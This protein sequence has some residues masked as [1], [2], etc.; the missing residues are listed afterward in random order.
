MSFEY[1]DAEASQHNMMTA[2]LPPWNSNNDSSAGM[3]CY[4]TRG[5][6]PG[7]GQKA[8]VSGANQGPPGPRLAA[9]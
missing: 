5:A 3:F 4:Y 1:S 7:I 9:V 8:G 6:G 2:L